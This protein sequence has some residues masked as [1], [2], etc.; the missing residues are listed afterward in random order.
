MV[1]LNSLTANSKGQ[2]G[3]RKRH[4]YSC[5]Y[6][7]WNCVYSHFAAGFQENVE[8]DDSD[9]GRGEVL[10]YSLSENAVTCELS[11]DVSQEYGGIRAMDPHPTFP[12]ILL[13]CEADGH[14]L[15]FDIFVGCIVNTFEERG[16]HILYPQFQLIPTECHFTSDGLSFVVATEYGS[17]SLYGY[18]D[19]SFYTMTP[20]EQFFQ[21]DFEQFAIE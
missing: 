3:R 10:V 17:I 11:R 21:T 1:L 18:D 2:R 5:T 14:I 20:V 19:K 4:T 15:L 6:I 16:F 9:R 12:N 13:I 7:C 8:E